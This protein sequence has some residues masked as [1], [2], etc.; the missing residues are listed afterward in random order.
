MIDLLPEEYRNELRNALRS[1]HPGQKT[2]AFSMDTVLSVFNDTIGVRAQEPPAPLK[3]TL[4]LQ[5]Q[6]TAGKDPITQVTQPQQQVQPQNFSVRGGRGRAAGYAGYTNYT[7]GAAY[8][9]VY[10]TYNRGAHSTGYQVPTSP[11][12]QIRQVRCSLCSGPEAFMHNTS[13]CLQ[14]PTPE[15]KRHKL[16]D[17]GRC[18]SCTRVVHQGGCSP[19]VR[20]CP[21]HPGLRHYP[22]LCDRIYQNQQRQHQPTGDPTSA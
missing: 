11:P 8:D 9:G 13:Q 5:A 2:A 14:F 22:W 15:D 21:A 7:R 20:E 3:G 18:I 17:L 12:Q 10:S 1:L 4:N 19:H 16:N 6:P